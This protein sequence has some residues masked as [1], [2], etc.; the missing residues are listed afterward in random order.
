M[1]ARKRI[2]CIILLLI[3]FLYG[4]TA[5]QVS[6][7]IRGTVI[8]KE[9]N[10]PLE[11]VSVAVI[12]DSTVL[13]G[14]ITDGS[15]AFA[16]SSIPVG[17]VDVAVSFVGYKRVY[18][19]NVQ[20]T[21]AKEVVMTIEVESSVE[22]MKEVL[23]S[24][25]RKGEAI[26]EM[27]VLSARAFS[28]EETQRYAGSRGDPARMASNFAG[29]SGT[30]DSRNDLVVRGNSPFGVLYRIDNVVVP[31]PNHFAVAGATG[32]SVNILTSR[33]LS[34]SDFMT[35][36]FPA[37]YGNAIAG[38]F[39][40]RMKNG[41]NRQHEYTAQVGL[42]GLEAFGEGPLSKKG[43]SSYIFNY[44]YATLEALVKLGIDIGTEAIPYYQDLQFKLNFPMKNGDN[45]SVFGI[46]GYSYINF[47]TSNKLRPEKRDIYASKDQDEYF[48]AGV[49][50]MGVTYT[51]QV[52][53]H[54]YS[55]TSF[56]ISTQYNRNNF[57]RIIRHVDSLTENFVVD[58]IYPKLAYF[59]IN[60]RYTL[61]Y[62]RNNK[63]SARSSIRYGV[64]AEMFQ[65]FF[66]DSNLLEPQFETTVSNFTW[67]KRLNTTTGIHLLLQ[68]Y[69]QWKYAINEKLTAVLGVHGQY[70]TLSNSVNV[71]PRMSLKWQFKQNQS[72]AFGYGLHSQMLPV[73]QYFVQ[74]NA[75]ER[76][77]SK[78]DFI[79]SMHAV[80]GY[81]VFFKKDIR[82]KAEAY[83]QYLWGIPVDTFAT[84]Y[85]ILNEGSGFDRFF[86]GKL[87][88]KGLGRNMGIEFTLEKFF[89]HNWF[90][91]FSASLYDSRLR[92]S[93]GKWYNS[94]FNGQ[95]ILNALGTK[96]FKWGKKRLNT[97][98][99]GGKITFGGGQRYTPYD[100]TLSQLREDAVVIDS[101]RN[102]KQ[103]KP[104]FRFDV[105]LNYSCNTKRFTH[106]VGIDLVNVAMYKNILRI[107]Y[108]SPQEPAREVYQL[109]FLPI[110]YYRLDFGIGKKQMG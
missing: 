31:N 78:L 7:T 82:I 43:K 8:D 94:D 90:F 106:E 15:G 48:R 41:N 60:T 107:Q 50:M 77:N 96:E 10:L 1:V 39:D 100:T 13:S 63:I 68:P 103:F 81:D 87:V 84:A 71:E 49:G 53:S 6:Q 11:G 74:S 19:P 72:L 64:T 56:A 46:G 99:I 55:K 33:M 17:R 75:G 62:T 89:T 37:E 67:I 20:L 16:I 57:N 104:Y 23:I 47:I 93:N 61:A 86:P 70:L 28:V 92:A 36:A 40:I 29:V 27:A 108:V 85:N 76:Y 52:N 83:F 79:R 69:I 88:N 18:I 5:Q 34:N 38:V 51:H 12:K 109:G 73:Y 26:N 97:I 25:A 65:P 35:A 80:A 102:S 3:C 30:D 32:G 14:A 110:F 91:M 66:T 101:L 24:G 54:E 42:F 9:S 95:Y 105:K 2:I 22:T 59:F 98:G 58:S 45:L 21:A 44:R 4:S